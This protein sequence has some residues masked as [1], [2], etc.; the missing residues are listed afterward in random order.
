MTTTSPMP[1]AMKAA[2]A[3]P[4]CLRDLVELGWVREA[5]TG[6]AAGLLGFP[7]Q[8]GHWTP[9]QWKD[10]ALHVLRIQDAALRAGATLTRVRPESV[11][12]VGSRPVWTDTGALAAHEGGQWRALNEYRLEFLYP[13]LRAAL[14]LGEAERPASLRAAGRALPASSW[15]HPV[16]LRHVHLGNWRRWPAAMAAES[17]RKAVE[18]LNPSPRWSPWQSHMVACED[19]LLRIL[20]KEAVRR[21]QPGLT[22]L[23]GD[24][25]GQFARAIAR[26]GADCVSFEA[27]ARDAAASY[28]HER[29]LGGTRLLTLTGSLRAG[30]RLAPG[31]PRAGL[32]VVLR[33]ALE[34]AERPGG[35]WAAALLRLGER[36]LFE[37]D[38]ASAGVPLGGVLE[39]LRPWFRASEVAEISCDGRC[40]CALEAA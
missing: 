6:A 21:R 2:A 12:F 24:S 31:A 38:P 18:G 3:R 32:V 33:S 40:L 16:A 13:L 20:L 36:I 39:G 23:F 7:S 5:G 35:E 34:P 25:A 27:N 37:H 28:L 30:V 22:Y 4:R 1:A 26:E 14:Q 11:R 10:A 8:P 9:E 19:G 15:L 29:A 17:L